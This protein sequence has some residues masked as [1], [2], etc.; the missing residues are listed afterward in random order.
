[1]SLGT[2]G[3]RFTTELS[4]WP[5]R[6]RRILHESR[7][8][9]PRSVRQRA[10]SRTQSSL[11]FA[12]GFRRRGVT[13]RTTLPVASGLPWMTPWPWP[14]VVSAAPDR[15]R[16]TTSRAGSL[17]RASGRNGSSAVSFLSRSAF[18]P[19]PGSTWPGPGNVKKWAVRHGCYWHH[20]AGC[21]CHGAPRNRPSGR[22]FRDNRRDAWSS[23]LEA[24]GFAVAVVWSAR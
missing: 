2:W 18:P 11:R 4:M 23:Q 6:R 1:M 19:E 5:V 13:E 3:G 8:T 24:A 10:S 22:K 12:P 15:L 9:E 7:E 20:H 16:P 14:G 17:G 21:S